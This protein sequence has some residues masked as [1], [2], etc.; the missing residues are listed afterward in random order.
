M[1]I[2]DRTDVKSF[3]FDIIPANQIERMLIFKS[4]SA[5]L[6]GDFAGGVVKIYTKGIPDKTGL[7]VDYSTSFRQGTT[8]QDFYQ[9]EQ[10]DYFWTG[11]NN[12]Y[13]DLPARFPSSINNVINNPI[14]VS[15]THL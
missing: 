14:A 12:G 6:P 3:S 2:R 9:P 5:D 1:C 11:F 4:P 8:L 15:Y 7:T 13:A 10:G